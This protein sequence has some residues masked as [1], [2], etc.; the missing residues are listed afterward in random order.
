MK[1]IGCYAGRDGLVRPVVRRGKKVTI[2]EAD[3][4]DRFFDMLDYLADIANC[5][6]LICY[7]RNG[8]WADSVP[9]LNSFLEENGAKM[10]RYDG[11]FSLAD[12]RKGRLSTGADHVSCL[13]D[14]RYPNEEVSWRE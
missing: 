6:T 12:L 2:L 11:F 4:S 7:S 8:F 10:L 3:L 1:L 5:T 14:R 13:H 9:D